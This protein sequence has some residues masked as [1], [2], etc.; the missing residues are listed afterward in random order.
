LVLDQLEELFTRSA[1]GAAAAASFRAQL[2][3]ALDAPGSPLCVLATL[4]SDFLDSFQVAPEL[5]GLAFETV[6]L[7]PM[8]VERLHR[9]ITGAGRPRRRGA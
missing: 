4:R 9:V 1:G 8:P 7:G 2:R 5:R 3:A 6:P